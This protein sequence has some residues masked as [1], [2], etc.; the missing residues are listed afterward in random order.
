MSVKHEVLEFFANYV[1][2]FKS[3]DAD[4]ISALW[5]TTGLFSSPDGNFALERDVFR[6][7]CSV[8][9]AFYAKQGVVLPTGNVV[10]FEELLPNI[11]QARVAYRML[12][13]DDAE[14]VKWEHVY[15]LRKTDAWR[16]SL[17]IADDEAAAWS[18]LGVSLS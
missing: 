9:L 4:A 11:V 8:L 15:I 13:E 14:I 12:N 1:D 16:I 5:D 17:S 18:S 2:A 10:S 7:H 6:E 3:R